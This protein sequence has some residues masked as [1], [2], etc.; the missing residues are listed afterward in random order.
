M[1]RAKWAVRIRTCC[2]EAGVYRPHFDDII[3]TLADMLA[4]RDTY[5]TLYKKSGGNPLV[6]HVNKAGA[7]NPEKNPAL[8]MIDEIN[9]DA[10]PY[11]RDLGLTPAAWRKLNG[12][13]SAQPPADPLGKMIESIRLVK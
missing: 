5:R 12:R 4:R 10:L 9:R 3:D 6:T 1:T 8:R 13:E 2:E 11:W 7:E